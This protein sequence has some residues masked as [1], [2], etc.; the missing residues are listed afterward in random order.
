MMT[1]AARVQLLAMALLLV[2]SG[3]RIFES[4]LDLRYRVVHAIIA[5]AATMVILWR[6]T[7]RR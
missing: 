5:T 1:V 3:P 7:R 6:L 2:V 4:S